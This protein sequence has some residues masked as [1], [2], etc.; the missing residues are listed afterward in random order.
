MTIR[1]I[2]RL[3]NDRPHVAVVGLLFAVL[4]FMATAGLLVTWVFS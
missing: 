3:W 4:V 2:D 1:W